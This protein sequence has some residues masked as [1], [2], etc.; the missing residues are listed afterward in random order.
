MGQFEAAPPFFWEVG[1]EKMFLSCFDISESL[2]KRLGKH[3]RLY[4]NGARV[5]HVGANERVYTCKLEFYD[6][7]DEPSVLEQTT[8]GKPLRSAILPLFLAS[9]D[10]NETGN[11]Q[12]P[13]RGIIRAAASNYRRVESTDERDHTV[14][15]A[16]WV[17]DNEDDTSPEKYQTTTVRSA[18]PKLEKLKASMDSDGWGSDAA[19]ELAKVAETLKNPLPEEL[20]GQALVQ[21]TLDIYAGLEAIERA[22]VD[23]FTAPADQPA[24]E[25]RAEQ[26]SPAQH[27]TI[28]RLLRLRDQ[29]PAA[30]KESTRGRPVVVSRTWNRPMTLMAIAT[31]TNT[32]MAD[33]LAANPGLDPFEILPGTKVSTLPRNQ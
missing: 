24:P 10:A 9:F 15:E 12:L 11:L 16:V 20:I 5:D 30:L 17:E 22:F 2:E 8:A 19:T 14:V 4:R 27:V 3:R 21:H 6:S 23:K 31:E 29:M 28:R 13:T 32:R 7:C 18:V 25:D 26:P 33:L 1:G